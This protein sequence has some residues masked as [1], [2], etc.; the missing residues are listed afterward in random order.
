MGYL[1][2]KMETNKKILDACCGGKHFWIDKSNSNVLF[3][4]IRREPKGSIKQQ[5][6]WECNPDIIGDFRKTQFKD[7]QFKHICWDI[8]HKLK[9]D[10]GL[11]TKKYGYL[12][13]N[14]REDLTKGFNELWRILDDYGTLCLKFADLDISIKELLA[15]FSKKPLYGTITKKGVN[16]SYWF[17]FVKLNS[18]VRNSSQP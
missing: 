11:I 18:E 4:D 14:W 16:N 10:S 5:P 9:K 1:K 12:G 6:N 8:P 17:V 13:E 2:N 3:M 7:N 15:L